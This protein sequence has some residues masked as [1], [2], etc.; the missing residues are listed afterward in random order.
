MQEINNLTMKGN[1][2]IHGGPIWSKMIPCERMIQVLEWHAAKSRWDT[3]RVSI[4]H[5]TRSS[6]LRFFQHP[7][8]ARWSPTSA[9]YFFLRIM[10]LFSKPDSKSRR[11]NWNLWKQ[12]K[13][14]LIQKMQQRKTKKLCTVPKERLRKAPQQVL[15]RSTVI[16][17]RRLNAIVVERITKL[18]TV[19]TRTANAHFAANS[20]ILRLCVAWSNITTRKLWTPRSS[21]KSMSK[22]SQIPLSMPFHPS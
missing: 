18:Q 5:S 17:Q 16:H 6:L 21:D 3:T 1:Y 13:S 4:P 11:M 12:S 19:P 22:Q 7:R 8:S 10:R 15:Q 14:Q 9:I 2:W 20:D